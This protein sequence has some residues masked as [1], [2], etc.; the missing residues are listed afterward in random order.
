MNRY[1]FKAGRF[2]SHTLILSEFKEAGHGR[3][4][5]DVGCGSGYLAH[6][7]SERGYQVTGLDKDKGSL[8][9]V[10]QRCQTI[11]ADIEKWSATGAEKFDYILLADVLE[12]LVN[13]FSA[14]NDLK[15]LLKKDG[16]IILSVPNVAHLYVRLMLLF[17]RWDY[18]ERGILD[19]SHLHFYT[20]ATL[21]KLFDDA[22]LRVLKIRLSTIPWALIWR[23]SFLVKTFEWI[24][25][26]AGVIF[27]NLFA[28]QWIISGTLSK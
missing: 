12:H 5:L 1:F 25:R 8:A 6:I 14:I 27:P 28:Y 15:P 11:E 4:V 7:L 18:Q 9:L 17:G 19:S 3:K 24:D 22:G 20:R 2:S 16:V 10:S 26:I 23:N 21:S 13:P